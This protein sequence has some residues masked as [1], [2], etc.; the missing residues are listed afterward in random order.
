MVGPGVVGDSRGL[1]VS[2]VEVGTTTVGISPG[3]GARDDCAGVAMVCLSGQEQERNRSGEWPSDYLDY[4]QPAATDPWCAGDSLFA[5]VA[6]WTG[7]LGRSGKLPSGQG[8]A[9]PYSAAAL[10]LW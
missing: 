7:R 9:V 8:V 1:S 4:A 5:L 2:C 3:A 6:H 10:K